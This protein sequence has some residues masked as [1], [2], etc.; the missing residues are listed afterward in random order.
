MN[1]FLE[2]L[3]L[4]V[5]KKEPLYMD[6][7]RLIYKQCLNTSKYKKVFFNFKINHN[8]SFKRTKFLELFSLNTQ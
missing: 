5:K 8:E 3:N 1:F 4:K 6:Y 2:L 7:M